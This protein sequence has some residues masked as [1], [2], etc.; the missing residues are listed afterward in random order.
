[1]KLRDINSISITGVRSKEVVERS[2]Q[3][4]DVVSNNEYSS[5]HLTKKFGMDLFT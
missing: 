5:L 2:P 1:M 4:S 3:Y